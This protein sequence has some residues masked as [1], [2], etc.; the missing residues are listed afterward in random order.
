MKE[1]VNKVNLSSLEP[2]NFFRFV[3]ARLACENQYMLMRR[4]CLHTVMQTLLLANQSGH[5]I[6]VILKMTILSCMP[7]DRYALH[8]CSHHL[9]MLMLRGG[10]SQ[11]GDVKSYTTYK[12]VQLKLYYE[13]TPQMTLSVC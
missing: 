12:T 6:L 2:E 10:K 1:W 3:L 5:T 13:R 7:L 9:T 4:P 8:S 11:R